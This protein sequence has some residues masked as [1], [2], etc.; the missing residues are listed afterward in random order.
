LTKISRNRRFALA[1]AVLSVAVLT[2]VPTAFAG[3][4]GGGKPTGG[5]SGAS[6]SLSLVTDV[7]GN[8]APNLG[9]TVTFNASTTATTEPHVR[10]QCF[11]G[12][13]LVYSNQA[14]FYASYP[15]PW[16]ENMTLNWTSGAADCTAQVYY[17]AGS[18]T[19]WSTSLGFHVDA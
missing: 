3:K 9:D 13:T 10:V 16:L 7:N 8:G 19:V 18:K 2:L 1:A 11:Q 12:A 17:F 14:G 4:G 15:W 6:L 5:S